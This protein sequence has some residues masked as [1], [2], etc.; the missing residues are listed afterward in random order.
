MAAAGEGH[1]PER[2]AEDKLCR[3]SPGPA[4]P[5]TRRSMPKT[6]ARKWRARGDSEG[7]GHR[8]DPPAAPPLTRKLSCRSGGF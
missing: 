8:G 4:A 5:H 6:R 7:G 1:G 2:G 3:V